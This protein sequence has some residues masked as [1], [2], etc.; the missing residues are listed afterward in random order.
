MFPLGLV[1]CFHFFVFFSVTSVRSLP[2]EMPALA[3]FW[4]RQVPC[5][6][7]HAPHFLLGLGGQLPEK[8]GMDRISLVHSLIQ[9]GKRLVVLLLIEIRY[10]DIIVGKP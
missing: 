3:F 1:R 2:M 5:P 9:V 8:L 10:R 7:G 6:V 4:K